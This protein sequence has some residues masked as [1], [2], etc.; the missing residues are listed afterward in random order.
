[1]G[2]EVAGED[3][4]GDRHDLELFDASEELEANGLDGDLGEGEEIA[5]YR[6]AQ[7]NGDRHAG[8]HQCDQDA[9]DDQTVH[10]RPSS[11]LESAS[12]RS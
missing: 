8:Q 9:K 5:Q 10:L 6:Q 3:K 7:G 2:E 4:E 11:L 1:M 12:A